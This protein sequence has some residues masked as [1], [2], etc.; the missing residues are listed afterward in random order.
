M[1]KYSQLGL[2]AKLVISI[3]AVFVLLLVSILS[4]IG[5][6]MK[7]VL[8]STVETIAD[9][10]VAKYANLFKS[11]LSEDMMISRTIAD[12]LE[13]LL[14]YDGEMKMKRTSEILQRTFLKHPK[15][16]AIYASWERKYV[17]PNWHKDYGRIR[18]TLDFAPKSDDDFSVIAYD[19]LNTFGDEINSS[20]Y[21][22]K[23]NKKDVL[24]DPYEDTYG[25]VVQTVTSVFNPMVYKGK[26]LGSSGIDIPLSRFAEIIDNAEKFYNSNIFLIS[27]DGVFVGNQVKDLVGKS[28]SVVNKNKT[29][30]IISKI[31]NGETFSMYNIVDGE[32]YYVTYY[33]INVVG[34]DTPW[35]VGIAVPYSEMLGLMRTNFILLLVVSIVGLIIV[36][37]LIFWLARGITEPIKKITK[38]LKLMSKGDINGIK[39]IS[40]KREDE[41][42]EIIE[43]ANVLV[44]NLHKTA[45]FANDIGGGNLETDFESLSN[46]DVLG[47]SLLNMRKSLHKANLE[48]EKRRN[49]EEKQSWA[50]KGYAKFGELLRNNTENM[51]TFTYNVISNL[52]K[53]TSSNQ[54]AM[55]LLNEDD[56]MDPYLVM[57]SCYAYDRKKFID[58]RIDLGSNLVGQCFLEGETIYMTDIPDNYISIT[59]GLGD[60]NPTALIIVPLK[61]NE[62]VFGVIELAGFDKYEPYKIAFIEKLAE[63][64]AS[65]I[66]TVKVNLQTISLL[67]ESKLKSEELAAQEEEMRQ[68]MEE[69]QTTQ[70]ESARRELDMNGILGAL[71]SAYIVLELS[72]DGDI[73]IMNENATKLLGGMASSMEGENIRKLLM[74]E[75]IEEFDEMWET[76]VNGDSVSRQRKIKRGTNEFII[77]ESYTPIYNDM[78][79][80]YKVLNIGVEIRE[81]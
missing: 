39:K 70:E 58:K 21:A 77:S 26:Y 65:T 63:S 75:E 32:N 20:Y 10:N 18:V 68:N 56:E 72:L 71:N 4:F 31:K 15:Y 59:S 46:K 14:P 81:E 61:F 1:K 43:S 22:T 40:I 16:R 50:T 79:E 33:P 11:Y 64:I 49:E 55:F 30:N 13:S 29:D 38:L 23:I 25:N 69:L 27:N 45:V 48:E 8:M 17:D 37:L 78:D 80:I 51:E 54:G 2:K 60:A 28:I 34:V 42:G 66:A 19:T 12:E 6:R 9:N 73:I 44:E 76:V 24:A 52:V 57:S 41:I 47:N 67:E 74:P 53:Y 3:L 7:P 35:S 5:I 36:I 62:K